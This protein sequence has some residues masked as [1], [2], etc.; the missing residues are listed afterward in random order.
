[1]KKKIL[2]Q[3]ASAVERYLRRRRSGE[4]LCLTGQNDTVAVQMGITAYPG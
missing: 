1:M 2:K 4:Y 3:R